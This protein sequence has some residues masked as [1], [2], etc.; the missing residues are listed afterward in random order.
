[1][2][3]EVVEYVLSE[4][5]KAMCM[6]SLWL[7]ERA[8]SFLEDSPPIFQLKL[9]RCLMSGFENHERGNWPTVKHEWSGVF[10]FGIKPTLHRLIGF[11]A[12]GNKTSFIA[13]DGFLKRKQKLS[14]TERAS[15]DEVARIKKDNDWEKKI[16]SS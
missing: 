15:I 8:L 5:E 12:S 1:M 11:Y 16:G 13:V 4:E 10:R 7:S 6:T 14:K 9:K 2:A 3:V